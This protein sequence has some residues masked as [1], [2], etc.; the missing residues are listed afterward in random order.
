MKKSCKSS[1][2]CCF[3]KQVS[4]YEIIKNGPRGATGATGSTLNT[5]EARDTVTLPAGSEAKVLTS[6][7]DDKVY[8][9]FYIPKGADG[10]QEKVVAG[11]T[12]NLE[13][14]EK[15]VV[16]DRFEEGVHYFDF[17]IPKGQKGETGPR[18]LP[19]E[20]GIS[21][22]I[23]IDGTETVE[24]DEDAE[25]QDD[26]GRNIHHLTFYIP[27][28][29]K[30]DKGDKGEPGE[31]GE[32]GAQG[33]KG[34]TGEKGEQGE[35]GPVGPSGLT[36]DINAT[37]YNSNQQTITNNTP[38][39]LTEIAMNNGF[40]ITDSRLVSPTTGSFLVSFS[41]NNASGAT[42]GDSIGVAVNGVINPATKRPLTASTN[43]SGT[44]A[45]IL[46]KNDEVTLVPS[47]GGQRTLLASGAPSAVLTLM[48]ISY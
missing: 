18:G 36:P 34:D 3:K 21:E 47:I 41:I 32:T 25:V 40:N 42:T 35:A 9:D 15:A 4:S 38:L 7:E 19:G 27:R 33:P 29:Q 45:L 2:N 30:G 11:E 20:I 43:T 16:T 28:G 6:C 10:K 17:S 13:A 26:Q 37:I 14:T 48:M 39:S 24:P 12:T 5:V 46:N 8:F 23:T 31:K 1:S 44:I 22:V